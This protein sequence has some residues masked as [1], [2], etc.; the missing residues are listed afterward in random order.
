[1]SEDGAVV[2][3]AQRWTD[4]AAPASRPRSWARLVRHGRV[5]QDVPFTGAKAHTEL[6]QFWAGLADRYEA[7][8]MTEDQMWDALRKR[9]G[10][11][12]VRCDRK[13]CAGALPVAW[14][15]CPGCGADARRVAAGSLSGVRRYP[16]VLLDLRKRL[17]PS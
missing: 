14:H 4:P 6:D 8:A 5:A 15:C 9:T 1:M 11:E 7:T 16:P 2:I 13:D 3:T 12:Q 17:D 10:I